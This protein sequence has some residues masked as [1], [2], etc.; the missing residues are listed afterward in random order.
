MGL[1]ARI[2]CSAVYG[3]IAAL[4]TVVLGLVFKFDVGRV[5]LD[6]QKQEAYWH[7]VVIIFVGVSA[8]A[9]MLQTPD[10]TGKG[11]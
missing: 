7:A 4:G 5:S 1:V 9:F 10:E 11:G 8:I 3:A 2:G 6:M